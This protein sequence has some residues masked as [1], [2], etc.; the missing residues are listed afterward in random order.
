MSGSPKTRRLR[1]GAFPTE[2][3]ESVPTVEHPKRLGKGV[4]SPVF[5]VAAHEHPKHGLVYVAAF[6]RH[7]AAEMAPV[8]YDW[9][10]VSK[11]SDG[12]QVFTVFAA[13]NSCRTLETGRPESGCTVYKG[14]GWERRNGKPTAPFGSPIAV[15]GVLEPS[16]PEHRAVAVVRQVCKAS[17]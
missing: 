9:L 16:A 17:R 6:G 7:S 13:C 15:L 3:L 5:Y 12:P 1:R 14:A 11:V 8:R 10:V 4:P 2:G